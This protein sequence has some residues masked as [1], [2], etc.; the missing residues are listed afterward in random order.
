MKKLTQ[1]QKIYAGAGGFVLLVGTII[2]IKKAK[3]NKQ[4]KQW[5]APD[6]FSLPPSGSSSGKKLITFPL[7]QGDFNNPMVLRFQKWAN[8][9]I[10]KV[11]MMKGNIPLLVEDGD[12]GVKTLEF[13]RILLKSDV[14][15]K[16]K[17]DQYGM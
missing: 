7:K 4:E 16:S 9:Q 11:R 8:K 12:F 2:G 6:D 3:A 15:S 10:G 17:F 14:I 13:V 5:L 1:K